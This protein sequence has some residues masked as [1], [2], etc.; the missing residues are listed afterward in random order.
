M[1]SFYG[2]KQGISF[3]IVKHFDGIN[4]PQPDANGNFTYTGNYYAV[5]SSGDFIKLSGTNDSPI[6]KTSENQ[7]AYKWKYQLN[8]G[9]TIN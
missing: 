9:V 5:N 6:V 2:G 7:N 4:I 3:N 1:E 8:N